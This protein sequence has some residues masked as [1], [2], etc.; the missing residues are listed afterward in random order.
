MVKEIWEN[1]LKNVNDKVLVNEQLCSEVSQILQTGGPYSIDI[2]DSIAKQVFFDALNNGAF[3][4]RVKN[5][6]T[7]TVYK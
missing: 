1:Y 5:F 3:P 6:A 7:G 2:F 4:L